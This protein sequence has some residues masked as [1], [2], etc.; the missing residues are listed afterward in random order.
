MYVKLLV[1][2]MYILI[3]LSHNIYLVI[4]FIFLQC[5]KFEMQFVQQYIINHLET[6][7]NISYKPNA[8]N[9]TLSGG[10]GE[11][12]TIIHNIMYIILKFSM[13]IGNMSTK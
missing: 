11:E 13:S 5:H 8:S 2:C 4:L 1:F 7:S 12:L 10:S 6:L 3:E 9:E